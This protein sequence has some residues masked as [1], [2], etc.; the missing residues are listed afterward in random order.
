[1]TIEARITNFDAG[2]EYLQHAIGD[3]KTDLRDLPATSA[4]RAS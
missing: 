3:L 1:M 4:S 2:A